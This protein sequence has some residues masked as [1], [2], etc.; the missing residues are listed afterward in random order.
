MTRLQRV[1]NNRYPENRIRSANAPVISA[2]VITANISWNDMD[3]VA[4]MVGANDTGAAPMP[5]SPAYF[6]PPR[7]PAWS[8]PNATVYPATIHTTVTTPSATMDCITV[9]RTFLARTRPPY[10]RARPGVMN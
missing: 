5:E 4:G 2:G 8:G 6:S 3:A 10:N 9:P 7:R 1:T